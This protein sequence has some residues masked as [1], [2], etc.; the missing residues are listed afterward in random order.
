MKLFSDFYN[1]RHFIK[2]HFIK[3]STLGKTKNQ[4]K[5]SEKCFFGKKVIEFLTKN[6]FYQKIAPHAKICVHKKAHLV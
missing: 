2:K 1:K 4:K 3:K 5:N 6:L